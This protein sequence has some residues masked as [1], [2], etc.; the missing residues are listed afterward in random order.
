MCNRLAKH[1]HN[2]LLIVS[3]GIINHIESYYNLILMMVELLFYAAVLFS[4]IPPL[5]VLEV[6]TIVVK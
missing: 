6:E 2:N 5:W 4:D 1:P 3:V